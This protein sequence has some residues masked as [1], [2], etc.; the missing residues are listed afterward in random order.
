MMDFHLIWRWITESGNPVGIISLSN[1]F[2]LFSHFMNSR[3]MLPFGLPLSFLHTSFPLR[4]SILASSKEV[5]N[6]Q[7]SIHL[8]ECLYLSHVHLQLIS[9]HVI[10]W[11]FVLTWL[12]SLSLSRRGVMWRSCVHDSG[13]CDVWVCQ[14]QVLMASR[15]GGVP[16]REVRQALL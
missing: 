7:L 12:L 13:F 4:L 1:G 6:H 3:V 10:S 16:C 14:G 8:K 2:C 9:F 11:H 5:Q 15:Q